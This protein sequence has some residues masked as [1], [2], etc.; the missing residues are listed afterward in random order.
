MIL[1]MDCYGIRTSV[2]SDVATQQF[3]TADFNRSVQIHHTSLD[4][5]DESRA[6]GRSQG[7]LMM[8]AEGLGDADSAS[9][10]CTI[11]LD[12]VTRH[13]L[14]VVPNQATADPRGSAIER[15]L[16]DA[17]KRGQS[18]MNREGRVIDAHAG[19]AA[20]VTVAYIAWPTA[21]VVQAG[22][23]AAFLWRTG[24]VDRIGAQAP[25][26]TIGGMSDQLYPAYTRTDLR[27]GDKLLL[28][29]QGVSRHL[30]E[31]QLAS[32]LSEPLPAEQLCQNIITAAAALD[33]AEHCAVV[34]RFD[35]GHSEGPAAPLGALPAGSTNDD[36]RPDHSND[37]DE[38]LRQATT[39]EKRQRVIPSA[40]VN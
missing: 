29:A 6:F 33:T 24:K 17:L 16:K 38:E 5:P 25:A 39:L 30:D 3:L 13:L 2:G 1:N 34:A 10:A 4:V 12:A 20:E 27:M 23:T 40:P 35:E 11:A 18:T 31:F 7:K 37:Q 28:C 21:H 22:R 32:Q 36:P 26:E 8:V 14:N 9:R 19:M 15:M